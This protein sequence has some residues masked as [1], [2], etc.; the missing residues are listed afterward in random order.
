V[1]IVLANLILGVAFLLSTFFTSSAWGNS[2]MFQATSTA[3]AHLVIS[4]A[5]F[6]WLKQPDAQ[7]L[8]LYGGA[9]LMLLLMLLQTT[10]AWG[11]LS[12]G[13]VGVNSPVPCYVSGSGA[14]RAASLLAGILLCSNIALGTLTYAWR[15]DFDGNGSGQ[16]L[17]LSIPSQSNPKGLGATSPSR[18]SATAA[19]GNSGNVDDDV[20]GGL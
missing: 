17:N 5:I 1:T 6:Q 4:Y 12:S 2:V 11:N 19:A 16:Y 3:A 20:E 15:S 14:D 18:S 9:F 10:L 13:F 7:K 8:D